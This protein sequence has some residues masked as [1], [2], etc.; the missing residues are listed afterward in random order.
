MNAWLV[1]GAIALGSYALRAVMLVLVTVKPLPPQ[2]QESMGLVGPAAVGALLA[3]LVLVHAGGVGAPS[4]AVL[5]A[6]A[7]AFA[8]TRRT[9]KLLHAVAVGFPVLWLG[10]ALTAAVGW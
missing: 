5:V 6:L 2:A 1:I 3:T 9:G 4:V 10:T 8:V 7:A